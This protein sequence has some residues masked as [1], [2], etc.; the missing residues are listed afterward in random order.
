MQ[1]VK[2]WNASGE[3]K[4]VVRTQTSLL[5]SQRIGSISC[6][7]FHPHRPLLASGSADAMVTLYPIEPLHKEGHASGSLPEA[8]SST[9]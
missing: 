1:V 2:L 3:Q 8:S 4:G 6:L 5:N 9:A 7:R